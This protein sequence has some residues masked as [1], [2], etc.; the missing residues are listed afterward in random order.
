[1]V[2]PMGELMKEHIQ[3]LVEYPPVQGGKSFD[4]SNVVEQVLS[5]GHE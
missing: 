4:M 2:E 1:M 3:T 5:K